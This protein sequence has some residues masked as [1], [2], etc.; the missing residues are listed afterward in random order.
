MRATATR[1]AIAAAAASRL[2]LFASADVTV[3]RRLYIATRHW[4]K[5]RAS[6]IMGLTE[7]LLC[8]PE[9]ASQ[10]CRT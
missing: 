8:R 1:V 10:K 4:N 6:S 3:I 2:Y 9:I 7:S 5:A